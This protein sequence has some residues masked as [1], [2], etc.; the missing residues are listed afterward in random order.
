[1]KVAMLAHAQIRRVSMIK[2]LPAS[3]RVINI[4]VGVVVPLEKRARV[5]D[6]FAHNV[7]AGHIQARLNIKDLTRGLRH[8]VKRRTIKPAQRGLHD[9][10]LDI[11][12][13]TNFFHALYIVGNKCRLNDERAVSQQCEASCFTK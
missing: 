5:L 7:V 1:M 12:G 2:I 6:Q 8:A 11:V 13:E 4:T 10:F 9:G 3:M